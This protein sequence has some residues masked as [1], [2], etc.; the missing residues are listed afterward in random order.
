MINM[1]KVLGLELIENG[2]WF[3]RKAFHLKPKKT[4]RSYIQSFLVNKGM[5]IGKMF[6]ADNNYFYTDIGT[7]KDIILHDWT[8]KK[9]YEEDIN[10][11]D[12]F[13]FN[14]KSNMQER[15]HITAVALARSITISDIKTGEFINWHRANVFLADEN[16][17]LK[18]WFLEPQ[19]DKVVEIVNYNQLINLTG[20][21]NRLNII[22][23]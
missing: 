16:N 3:L 10:D 6:F 2:I 11:C 19:T 13:A 23:F 5:P 1:Y 4:S 21:L 7:M 12:D 18:L 8:D 9:K 15:Y 14:F 20:W 22:D 17:V